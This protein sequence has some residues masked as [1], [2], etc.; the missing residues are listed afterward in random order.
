MYINALG[1]Q[2]LVNSGGALEH[3]V[4][5][6]KYSMEIT[7]NAYK[8]WVFTDQALPVDLLKRYTPIP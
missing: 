4:F 1:R 5:P 8:D 7:A 3:T 6:G 2:I